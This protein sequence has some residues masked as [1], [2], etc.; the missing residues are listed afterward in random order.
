M[1]V[2]LKNV[3][4]TS[5][6]VINDVA[7]GTLQTERRNFP[8]MCHHYKLVEYQKMGEGRVMCVAL[9]PLPIFEL[10]LRK[11]PEGVSFDLNN[12]GNRPQ[13]RKEVCAA[14]TREIKLSQ[15]CTT[16]SPLLY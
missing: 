4:C 6:C 13:T 12:P 15:R 11:V 5:L 2:N 8:Y 9:Y 7:D 14:G 16:I 1:P 3:D 10:T